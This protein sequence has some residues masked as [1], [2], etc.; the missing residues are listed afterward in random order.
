M[1]MT[2][3]AQENGPVLSTAMHK[4]QTQIS[5]GTRTLV[6]VGEAWLK[7]LTPSFF[8]GSRLQFLSYVWPDGSRHPYSLVGGFGVVFGCDGDRSA[9]RAVVRKEHPLT[10]GLL[11][12]VGVEHILFLTFWSVVFCCVLVCVCRVC[13]VSRYRFRA[14]VRASCEIEFPKLVVGT[15]VSRPHC[16][17]HF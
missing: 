16:C 2:T 8:V 3:P 10:N 12:L 14:T 11:H 1:L 9:V 17:G 6:L 7:T 13:C 15:L 5:V 4:R